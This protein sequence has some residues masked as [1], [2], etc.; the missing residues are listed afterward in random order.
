MAYGFISSNSLIWGSFF[1]GSFVSLEFVSTSWSLNLS[2]SILAGNILQSFA[3][4]VAVIKLSPVTIIT[5]TPAIW[6]SLTAFL[7]P[8]L[9]ESCKPNIPIYVKFFW[10]GKSP[11]S[12]SFSILSNSSFVISL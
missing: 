9:K 2:I 5:L 12:S 10:S 11:F 3:I 4:E 8:G 1:S 7:T 6:H